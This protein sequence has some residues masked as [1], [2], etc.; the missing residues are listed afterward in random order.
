MGGNE[1]RTFPNIQITKCRIY[2][3]DCWGIKAANQ[4]NAFATFRTLSYFVPKK[5]FNR[6]TQWG[7]NELRT[8]PNIRITKCEFPRM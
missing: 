3:Y 5:T 4:K 6:K 2:E 8:F 1:L 7:G